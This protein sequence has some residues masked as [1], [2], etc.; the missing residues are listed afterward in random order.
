M[1]FPSSKTLLIFD[2]FLRKIYNTVQDNNKQL[3]IL[4]EIR[5]DLL[6]KLMS[7]EICVSTNSNLNNENK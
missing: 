4:A 5:D 1:I 2:A 7:G 3:D 6:P